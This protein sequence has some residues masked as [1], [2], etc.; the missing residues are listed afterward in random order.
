MKQTTLDFCIQA[1]T[2][3]KG[4]VDPEAG[5]ERG[6]RTDEIFSSVEAF[7][8]CLEP[9]WRAVL[10]REFAKP[11]LPQ[12][13]AAVAREERRVFPPRCDV[14]SAFSCCPFPSVKVVI[15]GQ[16][17]YHGAG[18]AHGL[19]FSVRRGVRVPPSL[20]N[21]YKELR[22]EY[23]DEF[24][25]PQHGFLESWARQGVLMLNTAL[26]VAEDNANSHQSLGWSHFTN[27]VIA[28]VNERADGAVFLAWGREAKRICKNVD[29]KK[30]LLL[31]AGH[32]SPLSVR[33]FIGCGHFKEANRWLMERGKSPIR[34]NSVN[35]E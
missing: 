16:D 13:L 23:G 6:A 29:R 4:K 2:K 12:L 5:G 17:P 24:A 27:A 11:Y 3:P 18:Q 22:S 33:Y 10:Q 1:D 7:R 28:A 20:A 34:W 35:D 31:E 26:T 9:S 8:S 15:I 14:L 25:V 21:I 32:P 19:A 30:H